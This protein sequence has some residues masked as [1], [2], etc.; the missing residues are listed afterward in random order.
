MPP[1][2]LPA[3][4]SDLTPS[5]LKTPTGLPR[6]GFEASRGYYWVQKVNTWQAQ[7][8]E[9]SDGV[10]SVTAPGATTSRATQASRLGSP[11]RVELV[12]TNMDD[13]T[14]TI[15]DGTLKGYNVIKLEPPKLDRES[16]YGHLAG[17]NGVTAGSASRSMSGRH[18][19]WCMT[20]A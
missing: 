15:L 8:F 9:A 13:F 2:L 4:N 14:A 3:A 5:D 6:T 16:A 19:G 1:R 7:C 12:L 20:R 11:I 17:G 18:R 10:V